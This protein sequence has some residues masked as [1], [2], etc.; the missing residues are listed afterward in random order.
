MDGVYNQDLHGNSLVVE[1]GGVDNNMKE[2]KNTI[3]ALAEAISQIY[4]KAEE[5]NG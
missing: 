3:E 2:L 4:W 5:V 1:V